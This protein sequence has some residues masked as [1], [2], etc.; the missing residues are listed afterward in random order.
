VR[1]ILP[2]HPCCYTVDNEDSIRLRPVTKEVDRPH[3]H[4]EVGP[5][6]WLS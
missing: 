2:L 4:P 1:L 3:V 6:I 5:E